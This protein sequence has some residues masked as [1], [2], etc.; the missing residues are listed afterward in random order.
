MYI[1]NK[2]RT[3]KKAGELTDQDKIGI[4]KTAKLICTKLN[5]LWD[6]YK[7]AEQYLR[8]EKGSLQQ[9][10]QSQKL[11]DNVEKLWRNL[12]GLWYDWADVLTGPGNVQIN[13]KDLS[14]YDKTEI[15]KKTFS[16]DNMKLT[17]FN[18]TA[19]CKQ[20]D[21]NSTR[22]TAYPPD[23]IGETLRYLNDDEFSV[24]KMVSLSPENALRALVKPPYGLYFD[25]FRNFIRHLLHYGSIIIYENRAG[26]D[27]PIFAIYWDEDKV[28]R[29]GISPENFAN[30]GNLDG[31][32]KYDQIYKNA[33]SLDQK[34]N[35]LVLPKEQWPR[36]NTF[37]YKM[38]DNELVELGMTDP[39]VKNDEDR[40]FVLQV[41][42][43]YLTETN[44]DYGI[45][46]NRK[47]VVDG[48]FFGQ[49]KRDFR[50]E[51][52]SNS[53]L[54]FKPEMFQ[55]CWSYANPIF[56]KDVGR[57][58][59]FS[60]LLSQCS[61]FKFKYIMELLQEPRVR[62][63]W[64]RKYTGGSFLSHWF[65]T[66]PVYPSWQQVKSWNERQTERGDDVGLNFRYNDH[67]P[68]FFRG[69]TLGNNSTLF[70]TEEEFMIGTENPYLE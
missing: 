60:R 1:S 22:F 30:S 38:P 34:F 51:D 44:G 28:L 11:I 52:S 10:S 42:F 35:R 49:Y 27:W 66:I 41:M 37:Y 47:Y 18:W 36:N 53:P 69:E 14:E 8:L 55:P 40:E 61:V 67:L 62:N 4:K 13:I 26:K 57:V 33:R 64:V 23:F 5:A 43:D 3:K 65:Q 9:R 46:S 70:I 58:I 50:F 7:S 24:A 19:L 48:E 39:V 32:D 63:E 21:V 68:K 31:L 56:P 6:Q 2:K 25:F 45:M 20:Y 12:T 29:L 59:I 54:L 15:W 17:Y 16:V